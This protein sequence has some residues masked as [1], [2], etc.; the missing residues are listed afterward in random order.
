[1]CRRR[2]NALSPLFIFTYHRYLSL[3]NL[4]YFRKRFYDCSWFL[5]KFCP[6]VLPA[7]ETI[8]T[9]FSQ[10]QPPPKY[11]STKKSGALKIMYEVL[12]FGRVR[13]RYSRAEEQYGS[14][15][16]THSCGCTPEHES[17]QT[18]T[19]K[20]QGTAP[21]RQT[22]A[23]VRACHELNEAILPRALADIPLGIQ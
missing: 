20:Q 5:F 11:G 3:C 18:P 8:P 14:K 21:P 9:G 10:P 6:P 7:V 1:M 12:I 2:R 16:H 13:L 17:A 4:D 23:L 15:W 22:K 19:Q